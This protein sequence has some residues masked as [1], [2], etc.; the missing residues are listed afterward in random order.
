MRVPGRE[1]LPTTVA[2]SAHINIVRRLHR[3]SRTG[4]TRTPKCS[5]R[6]PLPQ[7]RP[8]PDIVPM[9]RIRAI[10][11]SADTTLRTIA[12][13]T[14]DRT[15]SAGRSSAVCGLSPGQDAQALAG[16]GARPV[17]RE[18]IAWCEAPFLGPVPCLVG[19]PAV[20]L[21]PFASPCLARS[22]VVGGRV[23]P[24]VYPDGLPRCPFGSPSTSHRL[25]A[26]W[27]VPARDIPNHSSPGPSLG[28]HTLFPIALSRS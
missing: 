5:E 9:A 27:G 16:R 3:P 22:G 23:R 21:V 12:H 17:V 4:M 13:T 7:P 20:R 26:S 6:V 2:S 11:V 19:R 24:V 18:R 10:T 25:A 8:D 15:W 28:R 1:P 14:H